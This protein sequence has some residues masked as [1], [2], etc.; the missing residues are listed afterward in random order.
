MADETSQEEPS[1]EEILAS[2]RRIISEGG[3]DEEKLDGARPSAGEDSALEAGSISGETQLADVAEPTGGG[4][5]VLELTD[6][7]DEHGNVVEALVPEQAE[8]VVETAETVKI[9]ELAAEPVAQFTHAEEVMENDEALI[10]TITE[11]ATAEHASHKEFC[12]ARD[13]LFSLLDRKHSASAQQNVRH[14]LRNCLER[15]DC[16]SG[17]HCQ[18]DGLDPTS[19]QRT[20]MVLDGRRRARAT[21]LV[22]ALASFRARR[23]APR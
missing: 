2:I 7:V 1:M 12:A 9:N 6:E 5:E 23:F 3:E 17:P 8:P 19:E 15:L 10:E 13:G 22:P 4:D 16:C 14:L 11:E 18:L 20:R 21:Q